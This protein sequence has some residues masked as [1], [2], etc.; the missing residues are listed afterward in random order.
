MAASASLT[1]RI[2]PRQDVGKDQLG[3]LVMAGIDPAFV[4]YILNIYF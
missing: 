3:Q 2:N 1:F 4:K